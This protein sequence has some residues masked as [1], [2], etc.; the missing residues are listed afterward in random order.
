MFSQ[1]KLRCTKESCKKEFLYCET[2]A[3][4][5]S[6]FGIED[7]CNFCRVSVRVKNA[8]DRD[9]HL[10]DECPRTLGYCSGFGCGHKKL[11]RDEFKNH[12]LLHCTA[13]PI[14]IVTNFR[15]MQTIEYEVERLEKVKLYLENKKRKSSERFKRRVC[16]YLLLS[17]SLTYIAWHFDH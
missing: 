2:M 17:F 15:F 3:H 8:E 13:M 11:F 10:M 16:G 7:E 9:L 1:L 6:C 4:L 12:L 14:S 5:E